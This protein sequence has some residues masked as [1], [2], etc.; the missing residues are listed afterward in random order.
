IPPVSTLAFDP[1]GVLYLARTGRRYTSGEADDKFP[2]YRIP[3][4]GARLSRD[5]EARYLHG[6]PLPNPQVGAVRGEREVFVTTFDRNR[7]IGVLYR[8]VDGRAELFAGGTPDPGQSPALKQPESVVVDATGGFFIADRDRG[9]IVR[10][11]SAGRVVDAR[12]AVI[13]R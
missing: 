6:P 2:L 9:L 8:M 1:Q 5:S 7:K 3:A 12:Y 13:T 11:D 4:G 10:L